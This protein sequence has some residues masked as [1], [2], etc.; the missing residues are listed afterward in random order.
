LSPWHFSM[1]DSKYVQGM[2]Q[3]EPCGA[4]YWIISSFQIPL[5]LIFT[6][7]ILCK[8]ESVQHQASN[9]EVLEKYD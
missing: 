8:K 3:I 9:H 1:C 2:I 5:A 7:W 4:G 6:A